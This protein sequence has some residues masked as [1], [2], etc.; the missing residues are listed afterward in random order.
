M[1]CVSKTKGETSRYILPEASI[2]QRFWISFRFSMSK[3]VSKWQWSAWARPTGQ[4]WDTYDLE[5]LK[6]GKT[7]ALLEQISRYAKMQVSAKVLVAVSKTKSRKK[8][9]VR[10]DRLICGSHLYDLGAEDMP[11]CKYQQRHWSSWAG[12]TGKYSDTYGLIG[13][14]VGQMT[15][16]SSWQR[17]RSSFEGMPTCM[18]QQ[19]YWS[20]RARPRR[21]KWD[22]YG[23]IGWFVGQI[24]KI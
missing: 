16:S 8:G 13:F 9:Y 21:E 11:K 19:R 5:H 22:T 24:S 17:F 2:Y 6:V 14:F 1:D 23:L 4:R 18:Y 7:S 15:L 20:S 12:P 10:A 3:K